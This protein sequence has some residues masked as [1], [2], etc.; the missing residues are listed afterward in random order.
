M[1]ELD[2][3]IMTLD[4]VL[5]ASG[6]VDKFSDWMCRDTVSGDIFRADH[7]LES[8]LEA[9]I[10][11]DD[12]ASAL[13]SAPHTL[14]SSKPATKKKREQLVKL[15]DQTRAAYES[16]LAQIDNYTG[17]QLGELIRAHDVRAPDTGNT[18]SEPVPFNL[19]FQTDIGPTG[20]S[21]GYLRPETAQGHFVNFARLLEFNNGRVPFA[22]A[23]V[24]KAFRNEISPR[25]GLLRVREF[26]MAEIEHFVDPQDKS[27]P[28]FAEVQDLVIPWL[29]KRVQEAGKT[30]LMHAT[31]GDAI[32]Q[33]MCDN[34]T[35]GYFVAR[36]WLYLT[37][38]GLDPSRI[39][40]RQH[41]ANEMAHY[42]SDCWDAE[43]QTSY[44]WI[45]CVGCADR[46]AYDLTVHAQRTKKN[47]SVLQKLDKPRVYELLV[48]TINLK[49]LG[50]RLKKDAK[51]V[52]AAVLAMDQDALSRLAS[53]LQ[54]S[55]Q[56]IVA[57]H[58]KEFILTPDLVSVAPTTIKEHVRSFTPNVIEPSFGMGRIFYALLEHAFWS[59]A[60][61]AQ[62]GVLSLPPLV[63]PIKAL[64]VPLSS[65]QEFRSLSQEVARKLR[66][67]GVSCRIDDGNTTIGRRYA[68]NDELGTPFACTIDFASLAKGTLTVR[69]RDSTMQ[70]IGPIDDI[71]QTITALSNGSMTWEEAR[72]K[73]PVY[74]GEQDS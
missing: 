66:H 72:T 39:R 35:L 57:A 62:R 6:H 9:R 55:G 65:K 45:E 61:D 16:I 47:L 68:R 53:Q 4:E 23:H 26:V 3:T 58:G 1:L 2:P 5:K 19:M 36:I 8:V 51:V 20:G 69:E 7:L 42:A 22:S 74:T 11:S 70:L 63:A 41:M 60:E 48:P 13:Q 12:G 15:P 64:V 31:V 18:V 56:S 10:Q 28:R 52:E 17:P 71:I 73:H 33:G 38:I 27:H 59:R 32:A 29:P 21:K 54:Q 44:G 34:Q 30:D 46:S 40:F 14:L 25:S 43:V 49:L 24:G 37:K 50:P 67:A